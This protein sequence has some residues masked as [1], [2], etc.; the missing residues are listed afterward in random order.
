MK[1]FLKVWK[2]RNKKNKNVQFSIRK[3]E[4]TRIARGLH[5]SVP[6]GSYIYHLAF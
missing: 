4:R 2:D 3:F 5:K 6:G 1:F